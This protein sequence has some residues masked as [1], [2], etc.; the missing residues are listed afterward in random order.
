MVSWTPNFELHVYKRLLPYVTVKVIQALHRIK[1]THPLKSQIVL[2]I[3]EGTIQTSDRR[4]A[5]GKDCS[6][7]CALQFNHSFHY[8]SHVA[9]TSHDH[10]T[11][12]G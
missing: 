4:Q 9:G 10:W 3:P 8:V 11:N 12:R 6:T 1:V 5:Q 2:A 7:F